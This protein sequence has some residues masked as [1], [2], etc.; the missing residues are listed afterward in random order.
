MPSRAS[1]RARTGGLPS[2]HHRPAR[3]GPRARS[4]PA[5]SRPT[6]T[7]GGTPDQQRRARHHVG[8]IRHTGRRRR[9]ARAAP[10]S[11]G[12]PTVSSPASRLPTPPPRLRRRRPRRDLPV[13]TG[14]KPRAQFI[15]KPKASF[16]VF[17][18]VFFAA[19]RRANDDGR[20]TA[21]RSDHTVKR[22]SSPRGGHESEPV[23]VTTETAALRCVKNTRTTPRRR[24]T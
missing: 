11:A 2:L 23:N 17:N 8:R 5:R 21:Q 12:R 20:S 24:R 10:R 6:R 19:P 18:W 16:L 3:C 7:G 4:P 13:P 1:S 22:R 14:R 15:S 9:T